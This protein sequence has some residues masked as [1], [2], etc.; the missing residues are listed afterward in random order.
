MHGLP[1]QMFGSTVM[2]ASNCSFDM[3]KTLHQPLLAAS[4]KAG[5]TPLPNRPSKAWNKKMKE[6]LANWRKQFA[7]RRKATDS[8]R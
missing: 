3:T 6:R 1:W 7:E 8:H 2:R 4:A 5:T